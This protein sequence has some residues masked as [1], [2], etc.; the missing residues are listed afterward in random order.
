[1]TGPMC[2]R[3][4]VGVGDSDSKDAEIIMAANHWFYIQNG[5][6]IGPVRQEKIKS[7]IR[8]GTIAAT[9]LVWKEGMKDWV[10]ANAVIVETAATPP[11]P[12][13][14]PQRT[15]T[16]DEGS[17]FGDVVSTGPNAINKT[18]Q[19]LGRFS[20]KQ[21]S[22]VVGGFAGLSVLAIVLFW[23]SGATT[24]KNHIQY[25]PENAVVVA[26]VDFVRIYNSKFFRKLKDEFDDELELDDF[27]AEMK[28]K[29]GLVPESIG[30]MSVWIE[31]DISSPGPLGT[32][33]VIKFSDEIPKRLEDWAEDNSEDDGRVGGV[34]MYS[35]KSKRRPA[36]A[37]PD[38]Y[39][40]V[41]GDAVL[42]EKILDREGATP[43]FNESMQAAVD[44]S[45]FNHSLTVAGSLKDADD[46]KDTMEQEAPG[47]KAL[48]RNLGPF[49]FHGDVTDQI[50]LT[51]KIQKSETRRSL[52][53]FTVS[54][55]AVEMIDIVKS[56]ER[57]L[58]RV[59]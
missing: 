12:P 7:L 48:L 31:P 14:R 45:D 47:S 32:L 10:P 59:L 22:V 37:F 30:S 19:F 54:V 27:F 56:M 34:K 51:A 38:S 5:Q 43:K 28:D 18:K 53:S 2:N 35:S 8:S 36:Y 42:V 20:T 9:D 26:H 25:A 15:T 24:I 44:S 11:P 33:I 49:I 39:T 57:A 40:A 50:E 55:D 17:T 6:Q 3:G 4:H 16:I 23:Y 29:T 46:L 58:K 52:V 1:M 41:I 21:I 13:V